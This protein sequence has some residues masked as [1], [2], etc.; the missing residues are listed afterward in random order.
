MKVLIIHP[1]FKDPGGVANFY[2]SLRDKFRKGIDHFAVG[3][4]VDENNVSKI[5]RIIFDYLRFIKELRNRKP[6][7]VH[8]NPSLNF[9]AIVRD[10]VFIF[11]S[12]RCFNIKVLVYIHGWEKSF[13][14]NLE[15][16]PLW[17]FRKVYNNADAFILNA[18]EFKNTMR[19]WGFKQPIYIETMAV[20]DDIVKGIDM[21]ATL[22]AR[23]EGGRYK[24]LF[25]SRIIR[26][27]GIYETVETFNI[28]QEK[29]QNIDLIIAGEGEELRNVK[30]YVKKRGIED[31]FFTGY[32][33]D[34]MKQDLLKDA[35]IFFFPT[36]Y[37]EGM[38]TCVLEAIAF[39]LPVVTRPMGGLAD[40]FEDGVHGFKTERK[41][42]N[43]FAGLIDQLIGNLNIYE[44]ISLHNY[45]YAKERFWASKV[46]ERIENIYEDVWQGKL[47]D[48]KDNYRTIQS[49]E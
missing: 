12:K 46:A 14:K 45:E 21:Q 9:K 34:N 1:E 32:V 37:G 10:G 2:L 4:R 6:D 49:T 17:L 13:E 36:Y 38:P 29:H 16:R 47:F 28:L 26:E 11:V 33:R 25:L 5:F 48:F 24:I 23:K 42:A 7:V 30:D 43:I 39:G 27:K 40:F 31:V 22:N 41:E 18:I 15:H 20:N 35:Y 8:V 44:K 19:Q 3:K